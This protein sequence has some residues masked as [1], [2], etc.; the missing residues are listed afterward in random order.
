MPRLPRPFAASAVVALAFAG[1]FAGVGAAPAPAHSSGPLPGYAGAPGDQNCTTCH[2]GNALN[3]GSAT[4]VVAP[5]AFVTPGMQHAVNVSLVG[6]QN[7]AKNGFQITARD[8]SGVFVGSWVVTMTPAAG[9]NLNK[10][11]NATGNPAY[12][13]HSAS[14]NTL[15]AWTMGWVAPA[16]LTPG[17][18]TFYAAGNDADGDTSASGD[19]I[20]VASAKAFQA[21]LTA[22]TPG[23]WPIGAPQTLTLHVPG[24]GGDLY[25]IAP[26]EDPTPF[27]LGGGMELQ[28]NPLTGFTALALS[29]P[30][31]FQGIV[32]V[33]DPAGDATA[34]IFVPT[35]PAL[36]GLPLH[37]AGVST[38]AA[39]VPTEVS[40]RVSVV[41]Q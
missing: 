25:F 13:E 21:S 26:S 10:T 14:G 8:N 27:D 40:N 2:T 6:A 22:T 39:Y 38:T 5:P 16:T 9:Y 15:A 23:T 12:H 29:T 32:G 28:V 7:A 11:R 33:L 35:E 37:F 17:P 34:T 18:I 4:F 30:S 1:V 24:R 3:A 31:I 19:F 41:F 20:Y 36:I